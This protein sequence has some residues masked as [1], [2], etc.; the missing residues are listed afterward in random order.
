[1]L[2][3]KLK[4]S[5]LEIPWF[6][7]VSNFDHWAALVMLRSEIDFEVHEAKSHGTNTKLSLHT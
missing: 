5:S 1:M 7:R 2:N 6:K 4:V 3:L